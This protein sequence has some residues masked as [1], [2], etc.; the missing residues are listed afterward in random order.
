MKLLE[1]II[2]VRYTKPASV[3][4]YVIS[5]H[6]TT[7]GA[8][9]L[10]C[11]FRMFSSLLLKSESFVIIGYSLLSLLSTGRQAVQPRIIP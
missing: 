1:S 3:Q 8:I 5:V 7:F 4:R 9:R 2:L 6:H 11:P 10:N